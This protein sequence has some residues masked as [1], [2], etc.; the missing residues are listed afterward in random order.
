MNNTKDA[1]EFQQKTRRDE[2]EAWKDMVLD[3]LSMIHAFT[4]ISDQQL[5]EP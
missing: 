2:H 3:G 4:C 5:G 1:H